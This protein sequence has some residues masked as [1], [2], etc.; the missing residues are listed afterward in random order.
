[1]NY[2]PAKAGGFSGESKIKKAMIVHNDRYDYSRFNYTK[3]NIKGIISCPPHGEFLQTP[4]NHLLGQECPKC[5]G[6]VKLNKEEFI[7]KANLKHLANYIKIQ[8]MSSLN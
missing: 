5:N 1:M 6:G 8:R 4:N 3:S 2:P 7:Q